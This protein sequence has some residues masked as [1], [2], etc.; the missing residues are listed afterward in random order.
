MQVQCKQQIART[1]SSSYQN[2]AQRTSLTSCSVLENLQTQT[3]PL[4]GNLPAPYKGTE[5]G[6]PF[7]IFFTGD[8]QWVRTKYEM[9]GE[10]EVLKVTEPCLCWVLTIA[11][12][13]C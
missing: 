5:G 10:S 6:Q 1:T 8:Q 4:A 12:D 2:G 13:D 11:K 9:L 7:K 3:L